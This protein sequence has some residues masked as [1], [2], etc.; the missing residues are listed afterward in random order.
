VDDY[1]S[2]VLEEYHASIEALFIPSLESALNEDISFYN[3]ERCIPFLYGLCTQ[4]MRTRGNKEHSIERCNADKS[5]DLRRVWNVMIHMSAANIGASLFLERRRRK[6]VF[7]RNRT[8]VPF[9]TGD[10]PTINLKANRRHP[11]E[12]LSLYYPVSP[13]LALLLGDV[14][15]EP[16]FP[17]EGLTAAQASTLNRKLFEACYKQ[18]FAQSEASLKA[19]RRE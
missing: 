9:I 19:L 16:Q 10:Q 2:N 13:Q 6:L 12:S 15:E 11:P 7:V 14:E 3:D 8:D 5:A 1:A 17:T 4:H 18:V